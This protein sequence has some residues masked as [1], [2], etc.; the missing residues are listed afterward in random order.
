MGTAS[1]FFG[2]GAVSL[3]GAGTGS[4]GFASSRAGAAISLCGAGGVGASGPSPGSPICPRMGDGVRLPPGAPSTR[5]IMTG[6]WSSLS[7]GCAGQNQMRR[8]SA[9][10]RQSEMIYEASRMRAYFFA[11]PE[12]RG[13]APERRAG[14]AGAG[15]PADAP[16]GWSAMTP[17]FSM[18][19]ALISPMTS[20]TRP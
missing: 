5:L 14:A 18:P 4:G 15:L 16:S 9:A 19:A 7:G 8:K 13:A 11:A 20:T 10:C 12:E 3:G 2:A 17:R 1:G 6:R